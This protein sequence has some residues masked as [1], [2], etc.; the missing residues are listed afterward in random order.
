MPITM[1]MFSSKYRKGGTFFPF[2]AKKSFIFTESVT[3][4]FRVASN[5]EM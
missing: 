5:R 3:E 1:E 2:S 4:V